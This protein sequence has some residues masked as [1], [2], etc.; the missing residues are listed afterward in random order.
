M[1]RAQ[2]DPINQSFF[3]YI[4]LHMFQALVSNEKENIFFL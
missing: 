4:F 2:N 3:F 1:K